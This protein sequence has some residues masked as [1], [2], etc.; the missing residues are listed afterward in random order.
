MSS[1][2]CLLAQWAKG[3]DIAIVVAEVTDVAWIQ[4]LARELPYAIGAAIN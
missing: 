2:P 3:C 1:T 4:S